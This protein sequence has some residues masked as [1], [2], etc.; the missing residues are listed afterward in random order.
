[1][2][3][4]GALFSLVNFILAGYQY[5]SAAGDPK[6]LQGAWGKIWQS[7][8][9]LTICFGSFILAAIFGYIFTKDAT[10]ILQPKLYGP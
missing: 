4:L 8:L 10:F 3:L 2:I 1:M 5:L 9:G 7:L 6:A